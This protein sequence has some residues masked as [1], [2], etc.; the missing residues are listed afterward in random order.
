MQGKDDDPKGANS[1]D[2]KGVLRRSNNFV[3]VAG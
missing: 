1:S 2:E 3:S